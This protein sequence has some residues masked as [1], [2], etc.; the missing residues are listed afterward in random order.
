LHCLRAGLA[1]EFLKS[2]LQLFDSL[3]FF[4]SEFLLRLLNRKAT[5]TDVRA[6]RR[7][8]NMTELAALKTILSH[9]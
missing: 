4:I 1:K 6:V 3:E 2:P 8:R 7:L 9:G 5:W